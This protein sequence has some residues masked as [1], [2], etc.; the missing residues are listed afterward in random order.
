MRLD[1]IGVKYLYHFTKVHA[2]YQIINIFVVVVVGKND[3]CLRYIARLG[4]TYDE[5]A[6]VFYAIM[7][8]EIIFGV[9]GIALELVLFLYGMQEQTGQ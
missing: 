5:M 3:E 1:G 7:D 4:Q 6:K 9:N 2:L 8:L